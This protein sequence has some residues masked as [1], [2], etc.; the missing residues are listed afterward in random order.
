MVLPRIR[1]YQQHE[2]SL[3]KGV[4]IQQYIPARILTDTRTV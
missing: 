1:T 4:L 2:K 3:H